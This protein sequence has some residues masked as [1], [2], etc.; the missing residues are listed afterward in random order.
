MSFDEGGIFVWYTDKDVP[1]FFTGRGARNFMKELIRVHSHRFAGKEFEVLKRKM[2]I[3][4]LVMELADKMIP[5]TEG[6]IKAEEI[7]KSQGQQY[8]SL[9]YR[10]GQALIV[11]EKLGWKAVK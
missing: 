6:R 9:E 4:V 7:S 2:A 11:L 3:E 8:L 1:L 10:M 5:S